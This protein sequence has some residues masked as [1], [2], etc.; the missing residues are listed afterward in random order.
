[1]ITVNI[2]EAKTHLSRL[3]EQAAAGEE[4]IIAK[5]SKPIAKLVPLGSGPSRRTLGIFKG[6]LNVPA[7][8]DAPLADEVIGLFENSPIELEPSS[9]VDIPI[10]GKRDQPH[11][12]TSRMTIASNGAT[13]TLSSLRKVSTGLHLASTSS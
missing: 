4:V 11:R 12:S 9:L 7:D 3:V 5:S 13:Q 6:E 2:H 8:F 1:M 10:P